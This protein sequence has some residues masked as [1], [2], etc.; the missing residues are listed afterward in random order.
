MKLLKDRLM[1]ESEEKKDILF[2]DVVD[3]YRNLPRKLLNFFKWQVHLYSLFTPWVSN[4]FIA[5][6]LLCSI[7]A[8]L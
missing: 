4:F 3:V 7:Y 2:L 8:H 5:H 6:L 1:K